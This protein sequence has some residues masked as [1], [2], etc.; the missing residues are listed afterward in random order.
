MRAIGL[1]GEAIMY[2]QGGRGVPSPAD[3]GCC[4]FP[5][6]ILVLQATA[7]THTL[8]GPSALNSGNS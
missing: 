1:P 7:S 2:T 6:D 5:A 4:C 3:W 8:P